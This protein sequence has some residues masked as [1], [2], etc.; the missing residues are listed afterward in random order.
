[1]DAQLVSGTIKIHDYDGI[2]WNIIVSVIFEEMEPFV[3]SMVSIL[4]DID[5]ANEI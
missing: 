2:N 4:N 5:K 3:E 1:M